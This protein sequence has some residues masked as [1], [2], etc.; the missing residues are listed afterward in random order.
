[1]WNLF[2]AAMLAC[3]LA[4]CASAPPPAPV[5][6]TRQRA[7][8][9]ASVAA[10]LSRAEN[11]NAAAKQW[12]QTAES[13]ALIYD[14]TN[15]A[16]AWH[17]LAQAER[18]VGKYDTAT[19]WLEKAANINQS[20]QQTN[21]WWRNQIVLLQIESDL[22]RTNALQSR[23]DSLNKSLPRL[24]AADLR[25]LFFNELAQWQ[26]QRGEYLLANSAIQQAETNFMQ[27]GL[28]NG[29]AA[30]CVKHARLAQHQGN[31]SLAIQEWRKA[32][33]RYEALADPA[34]VSVS[35]QGLGESQMENKELLDAGHYLELAVNNYR[36]LRKKPAL[37]NSLRLLIDCLKR[38]N[39]PTDTLAAE[40][41]T[42]EA[43]H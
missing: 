31:T 16:I 10:K 11:W 23:F 34:G 26:I 20:L 19:N 25:G 2:N 43:G 1:M 24:Q 29:M 13:F 38:Q 40:L 41:N 15:Q 3:M 42:V 21:E 28:S 12:Q 14:R 32:L 4:G 39:M 5:P 6:E 22:D 33:A 36:T 8:Y 17:N 35:L 27:A 37:A 30:V 9:S 18:E 7:F